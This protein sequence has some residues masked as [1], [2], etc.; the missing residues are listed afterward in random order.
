V[1]INLHIE[2]LIVEDMNLD[3]G[4][5]D[6]LCRAIRHQLLAQLSGPGLAAGIT[7][8]A[9]QR[10]VKGGVISFSD[11]DRPAVTGQKIGNAIYRGIGSGD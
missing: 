1:N 8:L 6:Q 5:K 9:D 4:G 3:A 10:I 11:S 7:G 2:R